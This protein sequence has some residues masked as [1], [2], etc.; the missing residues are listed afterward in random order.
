MKNIYIV[1]FCCFSL[2]TFGQEN[3]SYGLVDA[4]MNVI[5][6]N[7]TV[8][9]DA[10]VKFINANFKTENDKI[11]AAF[12]WTAS[13]ISYDVKNMMR[14]NP[15]ETSQEKI[16]NTL[17]TRK[18]VCIDYAEVFKD[19]LT[20]IGIET[21]IID[22]YTKQNGK[23]ATLAHSWTAARINNKWYLFDP[24]WGAGYEIGRAHV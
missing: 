13:N 19:V 3:A 17:K 4:K 5:P 18:G 12:Y 21:Y 7:A 16:E 6:A 24:T 1:L 9:T 20:K 22:G 2:L 11:R 15:F 10:I 8:S 23:I 14:Q